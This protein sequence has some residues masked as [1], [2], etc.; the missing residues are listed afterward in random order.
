MIYTRIKS[1]FQLLDVLH[2]F[3]AGRGTGT[4][5]ME[6]KITQ[7]LVSVDQDS[8]FFVFLYQIKAYDNID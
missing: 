4:A 1:V 3:R 8:L 5:T 6:L 7:D 2:R